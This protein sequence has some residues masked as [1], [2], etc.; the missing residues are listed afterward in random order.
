MAESKVQFLNTTRHQLSGIFTDAKSDKVAILCHG[1]ASSKDGF[2]YPKMAKALAAKKISSLRF[3]FT[4]NGESDGAF[5]FGNY[6]QEVGSR[7][8]E[9]SMHWL[10][11][12]HLEP[13]DMPPHIPSL[14]AHVQL[15]SA[16]MQPACRLLGQ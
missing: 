6:L 1:Y 2:V 7:N 15:V 4:G 5:E 8:A 14:P 9:L 12:A 10:Q 16:F 13:N 3:D 11:A